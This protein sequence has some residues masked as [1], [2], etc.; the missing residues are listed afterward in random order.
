[1]PGPGSPRALPLVSFVLALLGLADAVYLTVAHFTTSAILACSG[2]GL[3]DCAQVTTSPQ[4]YLFG[5]PVAVLGLAY[6]LVA[7]VVYSPPLWRSTRP[8]VARVRLV[9][10]AGAMAFVL[11]LLYAELILIGH[12]CLYCT[13][14]HVIVFALFVLTVLSHTRPHAR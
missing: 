2:G 8:A 7:V 9:S 10:A 5:V 1:M 6:F 14:A 13:G 11:W 3:V 12:I 4:S